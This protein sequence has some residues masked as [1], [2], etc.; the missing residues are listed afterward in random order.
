MHQIISPLLET[1]EDGLTVYRK[2]LDTISQ[3]R[4][5]AKRS[6]KDQ[7]GRVGEAKQALVIQSRQIENRRQTL[8]AELANQYHIHDR[9]LT[10]RRLCTFLEEPYASRLKTTAGE[11]K[12]LVQTVQRENQANARLFSQ[13][14]D[15]VHSSL[16]LINE[17]VYSPAVYQKPGSEQ[18]MQGYAGDRGKVFCGSV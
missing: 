2:M 3:E 8:V 7:L 1:L 5:A 11:L 10:I 4:D 13:A 16:K 6:D 15:L 18:R 14:L 9:P 17:L 12:T